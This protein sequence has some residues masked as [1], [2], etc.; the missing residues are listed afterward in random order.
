MERFD[1]IYVI[2]YPVL[3]DRKQRV[4]A[5]FR[6]HGITNYTFYEGNPRESV[7]VEKVTQFFSPDRNDRL[8]KAAS[9]DVTAPEVLVEPS[10]G[11]I[12]T[13]ISHIEVWQDLVTCGHGRC[14]ILEDDVIFPP[15]ALVNMD[16]YMDVLPDDLDIG[17]LHDGCGQHY[18][19]SFHT[20]TGS[21]LWHLTPRPL[22]RTCCSY[23]ITESA[24]RKLLSTIVPFHLPI[25]WEMNYQ[26]ALHK[27]RVYWAEPTILSEGSMTGAY[28]SSLR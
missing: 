17:V 15:D 16:K 13:T 7:P 5:F 3:R 8:R 19:T 22:M 21:A 26:N 18:E 12:C 25:D 6:Q 24:A 2:H 9:T 11:A 4:Q 28:S 1:K 23:I 27:L 10:L 20:K 14:L